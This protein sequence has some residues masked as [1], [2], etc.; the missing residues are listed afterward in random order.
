A[1]K[2]AGI[3]VQSLEFGIGKDI[4]AIEPEL[5]GVVKQV[6]TTPEKLA[7][8]MVELIKLACKDKKPCE[9]V[10]EV[11]TANDPIT[12]AGF[13][14]V[15]AVPDVNVVQRIPSQYDPAVF[16]KGLTD[17][18]AT[19]PNVDV[20]FAAA[21][22]GAIA[23]VDPIKAAGKQDQILIL[24]NGASRPG[25]AAV[26]DGSIFG[27]I[28]TWPFKMGEAT[29][30]AAVQAVNGDS[31]DPKGVDGLSLNEPLLITKEN[32]DQVTAEW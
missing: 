27:T 3:P 14:A 12:N 25:V 21:D 28:G 19:K 1:A 18:L 32:V 15:D 4:N 9:V 20:V 31:T 8:H 22:F 5:D 16:V 23:A 6:V 24:G 11:A 2:A 17:V 30:T 7:E 13:D 29:G 26:K 10:G